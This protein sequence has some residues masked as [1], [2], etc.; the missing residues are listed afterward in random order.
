MIIFHFKILVSGNQ[1]TANIAGSFLDAFTIKYQSPPASTEL[2]PEYGGANAGEEQGADSI[3]YLFIVQFG[4]FALNLYAVRQGADC[5]LIQ[6][7]KLLVTGLARALL[8]LFR[9]IAM[10]L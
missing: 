3:R 5:I 8:A 4:R 2:I 6:P 1:F 10:A 7:G 9:C